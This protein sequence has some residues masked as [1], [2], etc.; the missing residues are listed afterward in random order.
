MSTAPPPPRSSILKGTIIA[1][2]VTAG[3]VGATAWLW[4][5]GQ[6][7]DGDTA[8]IEAALLAPGADRAERLLTPT[9]E[10]LRLGKR[11]YAAQCAAC[12]GNEGAGDGNGSLRL[13]VKPRD[14]R[15]QPLNEYRNGATPLAIYHTLTHGIGGIMPTFPF[16]DRT[17]KF[18]VAHYVRTFMPE[19]P[20]D[21]P[22]KVAEFRA[23]LNAPM[24]S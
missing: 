8:A 14:F 23:K 7:P 21:P 3:M 1:F 9:P 13:A 6:R 18:A 20:T 17:Q 15:H 19:A 4:S 16:L 12:H 2:A 10:M 11:I 22:E 24:G 5:I